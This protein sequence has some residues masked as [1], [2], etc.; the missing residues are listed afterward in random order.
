MFANLF[1]VPENCLFPSHKKGNEMLY[2]LG[3]CISIHWQ[4]YI[5]VEHREPAISSHPPN[6]KAA[7]VMFRLLQSPLKHIAATGE[8][9][10]RP[11]KWVLLPRLPCLTSDSGD[12]LSLRQIRTP[13]PTRALCPHPNLMS[14][15]QQLCWRGHWWYL[16]WRRSVA[17]TL[18]LSCPNNG[19]WQIPFT[20]KCKLSYWSVLTQAWGEPHHRGS[21]PLVED[22]VPPPSSKSLV[23]EKMKFSS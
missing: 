5:C 22:S 3:C 17:P 12:I 1:L 7:V 18:T 15:A 14:C 19:I 8:K 11:C 20:S 23:L 2:L 21:G 16:G 9:P 10:Q 13:S 6:A 4:C